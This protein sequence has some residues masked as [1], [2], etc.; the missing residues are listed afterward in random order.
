MKTEGIGEGTEGAAGTTS[1]AGVGD[2]PGSE[3]DPG[4]RQN[5]N[6][7]AV[8]ASLGGN[9][10]VGT[11]ASG[12]D[13]ERVAN[14]VLRRWHLAL[15]TDRSGVLR[16]ASAEVR[17]ALEGLNSLLAEGSAGYREELRVSGPPR[18]FG[19]EFATYA[20]A[21][22]D[23]GVV[24]LATTL[25]NQ[26]DPSAAWMTW[27][28][29][30]AREGLGQ[31]QYRSGGAALGRLVRLMPVKGYPRPRILELEPLTRSL[32]RNA[33][34]FQPFQEYTVQSGDSMYVVRSRIRGQGLQVDYGWMRDFNNKR[35]FDLV[36]GE[37]LKIPTTPLSIQAWRGAQLLAVFSGEFPIR[38][39]EISIGVAGEETPLGNFTVGLEEKDPVYWPKG[40]A[41]IPYGNAD[42]PL[43]ERWIGFKESPSYGIHGTNSES[44]IGS[45]ETQGC[46]RLHNDQVIDLFDL[47]DQ[48]TAIT[49]QP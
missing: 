12:G 17:A 10:E 15:A 11:R 26:P 38:L 5:A 4:S 6:S 18:V 34:R 44:T 47:I 19:A 43:G 3:Q 7:R 22:A 13:E 48:G 1:E 14:L 23:D 41:A 8:E 29:V 25:K 31:E 30:L 24:G 36:E 46:L 2:G 32:S 27:T 49:I 33:F 9:G 20:K 16:T 37:E 39:Y 40:R 42:N 45:R 21:F 35:N 28:E